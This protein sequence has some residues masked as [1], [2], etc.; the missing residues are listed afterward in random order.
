MV[1]SL[2][3]IS[4]TVL[5][6]R[7]DGLSRAVF[8]IDLLLTILILAGVR[9]S[10]WLFDHTL[11]RASKPRCVLVDGAPSRLV[12]AY[13]DDV[14][15]KHELAEVIFAGPEN[16]GWLTELQKRIGRNHI[17]AIYCGPVADA[18]IRDNVAKLAA[19]HGLQC[20]EINFSIQEVPHHLGRAV[21]LKSLRITKSSGGRSL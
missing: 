3:F 10:G 9:S 20:Y 5:W 16:A 6:N 13:F 18:N 11:R 2:A 1:G 19:A 15:A 8:G 7:F 14:V 4:A 21:P 17:Q 12:T